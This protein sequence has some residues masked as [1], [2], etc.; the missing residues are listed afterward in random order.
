MVLQNYKGLRTLRTFSKIPTMLEIQSHQE[1]KAILMHQTDLA[2]I[3]QIQPIYS[4]KWNCF[5]F[6]IFHSVNW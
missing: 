4:K 1:V 2:N 5:L 3:S 6:C